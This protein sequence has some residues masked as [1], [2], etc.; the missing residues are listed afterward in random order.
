MKTRKIRKR[1]F[2]KKDIPAGSAIY[3]G[4]TEPFPTQLTITYHDAAHHYIQKEISLENLSHVLAEQAKQVVWLNVSGLKNT[5]IIH[6]LGQT[7]AIHPLVIEDLLNTEHV[8][9]VEF[10][11][12]YLF[13]ITKFPVCTTGTEPLKVEQFS[14]I[15]KDNLLITFQEEHATI[16]ST[17]EKKIKDF[18]I[19]QI[20]Y[21]IID[22]IIDDHYASVEYKGNLLEELEDKLINNQLNIDLGQLYAI[23]RDMLRL[24]KN[25]LILQ[26]I[27]IQLLREQSRFLAGLSDIYLHDLHDHLLRIAEAIDIHYELSAN[28]LQVYLSSISNKTNETMKILTLFAATFIPLSFIASLYGMNFTYIPGASWKWGYF[29]AIGG[30]AALGGGL[31]MFFRKKGW[32]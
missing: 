14:L 22:T 26:N 15:V 4:D 10:F 12:D 20:V 17:I 19:G 11:A 8:S 31:V 28:V 9:K 7:L 30:M 1:S 5:E 23:K 18:S 29:A 32:V 25:V 21:G 6:Q 27:V 13:M 16:V 3:I 2:Y 24:R